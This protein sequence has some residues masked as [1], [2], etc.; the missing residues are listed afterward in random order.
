MTVTAQQGGDG[1]VSVWFSYDSTGVGVS[2]SDV[3]CEVQGQCAVDASVRVC[4]NPAPGV[5][6]FPVPCRSS[7]VLKG[8]AI[9]C[10]EFSLVFVSIL[11]PSDSCILSKALRTTQ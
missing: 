7:S 6:G 3:S 5:S 9:V 11:A 1:A 10:P 4:G 8:L 2:S